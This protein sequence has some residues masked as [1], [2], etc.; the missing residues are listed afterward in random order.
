MAGWLKQG[1]SSLG[2]GISTLTKEILAEEPPDHHGDF[3]GAPPAATSSSGGDGRTSSHSFEA[4]GA[5]AEI[6]RL[7]AMVIELEE[8]STQAEAL[9]NAKYQQVV[10]ELES[11]TVLQRNEISQLQQQLSSHHVGGVSNGQP[12]QGG[13][14]DV[15]RDIDLFSSSPPPPLPELF[16]SRDGVS[17]SRS[18]SPDDGGRGHPHLS[19]RDS[20][21]LDAGLVEALETELREK[22]STIRHLTQEIARSKASMAERESV[23]P[24]TSAPRSEAEMQTE[25]LEAVVVIPRTAHTETQTPA[26]MIS[27]MKVQTETEPTPSS[28]TAETE[29]QTDQQ[30][31][32]QTVDAGVQ[33][34]WEMSDVDCQTPLPQVTDQAIQQDPDINRTCTPLT[35]R[36]SQAKRIPTVDAVVQ[37]TEWPTVS[38]E[39]Q[40]TQSNPDVSDRDS[41][42]EITGDVILFQDFQLAAEREQD[43]RELVQQLE[44]QVA[45]GTASEAYHTNEVRASLADLSA[46]VRILTEARDLSLAELHGAEK[47]NGELVQSAVE[48]AAGRRA[49]QAGAP[50]RERTGEGARPAERPQFGEPGAG[51]D[52]QLGRLGSATGGKQ[53]SPHVRCT[54][55]RGGR[56]HGR[57]VRRAAAALDEKSHQLTALQEEVARKEGARVDAALMKNMLMGYLVGPRNV[58]ADI[59][60]M[61][62]ATLNFDELERH[63]VQSNQTSTLRALFGFRDVLPLVGGESHA[64]N[65]RFVQQYAGEVYRTGEQAES[66]TAVLNGVPSTVFHDDGLRGGGRA[67]Q[68][69]TDPSMAQ[70]RMLEDILNGPGDADSD[71]SRNVDIV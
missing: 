42:S 19:H 24:T 54:S 53:P 67:H 31:S 37:T 15:F 20:S 11:V 17:R 60:R 21:S 48:S 36:P 18:F 9:A 7:R 26:S 39:T 35:K 57:A 4:L 30:E 58:Q 56:G 34:D 63:K 65:G 29:V 40:S 43:L 71:T 8:R 32:R 66:G 33:L 49:P 38:Q 52:R 25:Q 61:M 3:S 12:V 41:Q 45:I 62:M 64:R 5:R 50:H 44:S 13:D 6:E 47:R 28:P 46:Q 16:P 59:L 1:L 70:D 23:V 68:Q 14:A 27:D 10:R 55:R 22:D 69:A 2:E 51:V